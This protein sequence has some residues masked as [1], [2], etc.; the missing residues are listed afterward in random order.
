MTASGRVER[1]KGKEASSKLV[2][3]TAIFRN[4]EVKTDCK[5]VHTIQQN[6]GNR[7]GEDIWGHLLEQQVVVTFSFWC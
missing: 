2:I 7:T 5:S 6:C 1:K 4:L 3:V